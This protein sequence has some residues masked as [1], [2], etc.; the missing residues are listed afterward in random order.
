[1]GW[2]EGEGLG[3]RGN[4]S[5]TALRAMKRQNGL[6][7]GAKIQSEGGS[8]ESANHFS[9]VLANLQTHHESEP[10]KSKKKKS[11]L[12]LAQNRVTSGYAQKMRQA[13]FGQKSAD[14]MACIFG[15][16]EIAVAVELKESESEEK[17]TKKKKRT[18]DSIA[19][20]TIT[21]EEK[22]EKKRRKKEKKK[23]K[24]EKSP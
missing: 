21:S 3:K 10:K 1:M 4:A 12:T 23:R 5:T 8:S 9:A 14:D 15:N 19:G 18:D 6:G 17:Q 2:K 13:K 24:S 11:K 7:L 20:C 22:R 16:R